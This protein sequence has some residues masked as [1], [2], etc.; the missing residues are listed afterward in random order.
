MS[1]YPDWFLYA[2]GI[3]A[4]LYVISAFAVLRWKKW[5]F[6]LFTLTASIPLNL[7]LYFGLS[8]VYSVVVLIRVSILFGVLQIG[9]DK[10]GWSQLN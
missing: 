1:G 3:L 4:V 5:G 2:M 9:V 7:N 6:W 8:I 10:I